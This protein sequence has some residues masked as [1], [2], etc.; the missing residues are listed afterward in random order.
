M[1]KNTPSTLLVADAAHAS[2]PLPMP[3]MQDERAEDRAVHLRDYWL[4]LVKRRWWFFGVFLLV[5]LVAGL[6]AFL[7]EPVY[8]GKITLQIVQDNP[9]AVMGGNSIDPLGALTGTSEMDRFYE[10]QYRML[11]S[12]V[13][14]YGIIDALNLREHRSYKELEAANA[15]IPP[16]VIRQKY[17]ESLLRNLNVVPAKKSFLVDVSFRSTDR[18]LAKR[19]PEAIQSEYLKLAMSTRQQSYTLIREW[20][21]QELTRLGKKLESSEQNVYANGR[22]TDFLSIEDNQYNVVVQKYV[23]LGRALSTAQAEKAVK[24]ALYTQLRE[25]GLDAPVATNNPLIQ[26][27][28]QQLIGLESQASGT[29]AILGSQFPD[30]KA[31]AA[32]VK[33]LRDHLAKEL[34]RL[35]YS[36][37][38]DYQTAS[39]AEALLQKEFDAQKSRVADMQNNLVQHHILLRDLQTNQTLYEAL[40]TRMKEASI[41]GTMVSSNVS[42]ITPA[43]IPYRPWMPRKG[44]FLG[45]GA[46]IGMVCGIIAA[47]FIE[48][49]DNSIKSVEELERVCNIPPLGIIPRVEP[50]GTRNHERAQFLE[51]LPYNAPLSMVSEAVYHICTAIMLSASGAPPQVITMTSANPGEGKSTTSTHVAVGL[52]GTGRKCLLVDCDLRKPRLHS[53]FG[54]SCKYGITNCITGGATLEE[55]IQATS[56]PNLYFISAGPPPPNPGD[57]L[58]SE[59]FRNMVDTLRKSFRHI[60]INSP[61]VI[62]FADART[63]SSCADGAILTVKHLST[64]REAGKLAVQLLSRNN[65]R[66]LGGILTMARKE[67]MGYGGYYEYYRNY[68]KYFSGYGKG[69]AGEEQGD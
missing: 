46:L 11:Q 47:F 5:M 60:V 32:R 41:A 50:G 16:E 13:L 9:S 62:G 2:V 42:V 43:E 35:E 24:E 10:T 34:K 45:V 30:Q 19:V 8:M 12:P 49:M 22:K 29:G 66:I 54:V 53:V 15:G 44:L 31:D 65:L 59:A 17:A 68:N 63:L 51:L 61:P 14:A 28:R 64:T 4:I 67:G 57:L 1:Q 56:V 48:Y 21:D 39:R 3:H 26:Q 69:R 40:L 58:I 37:Q 38:A 33:E 20:L 25:K 55:I 23:E 52:A 7:M 36:A 6:V 27:L 18:E